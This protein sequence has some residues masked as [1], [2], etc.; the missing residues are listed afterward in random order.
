MELLLASTNAHKL[1]EL[2]TMLAPMGVRVLTPDDAGGLPH[3]EEDGETFQAN[4]RKKAISAARASGNW[5]LADDSGLEVDALDDDPGVFSA[6]Y[7]G[8]GSTDAENNAKLLA[9]LA[10]VPDSERQARFVCALCLARPDGTPAAE[11]EGVA[12]GEI[13]HAPRGTGGF[14]YDPLFVFVEPGFPAT[15]KAFA[16]LSP[17]EKSEVSHRGRALRA[18]TK[19]LIELLGAPS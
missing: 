3:V 10:K 18:L 14:G 7:A 9:K 2:S 1:D 5:A 6:R 19:E 4:A 12:H 15:G 16:E 11:L 13:L 8:E 17:T